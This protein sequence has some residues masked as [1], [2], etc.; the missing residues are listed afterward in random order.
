MSVYSGFATRSQ[1][2]SYNRNIYNLLCLLQ[3]RIVRSIRKGILY[4]LKI[5]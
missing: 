2:D 3:I 1:E 4:K 5:T